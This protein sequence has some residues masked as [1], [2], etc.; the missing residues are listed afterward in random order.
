MLRREDNTMYTCMTVQFGDFSAGE[1]FLGAPVPYVH[2]S[3]RRRSCV[4]LSA[5]DSD[6]GCQSSAEDEIFSTIF[7]DGGVEHA[8]ITFSGC[9]C[10]TGFCCG[11]FVSKPWFV[12]L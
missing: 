1:A 4:Q 12:I 10:F 2:Y 3:S 7:N 6:S 5:E 9:F 8:D 11:V